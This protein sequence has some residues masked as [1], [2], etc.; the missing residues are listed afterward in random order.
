MFFLFLYHFLIFSYFRM[1][2]FNAW[3]K[4]FSHEFD[5]LSQIIISSWLL[6]KW[7]YIKTNSNWCSMMKI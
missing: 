7:K 6:L 4:L 1:D 2:Y 3:N 5:V